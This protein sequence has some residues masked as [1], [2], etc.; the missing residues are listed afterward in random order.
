VVI[1]MAKALSRE[2]G[3]SA[4]ELLVV[5]TIVGILGA[6]AM[7]SLRRLMDTQKVRSI[8]SDLFADLSYARGEAIAR[9]H[10][11]QVQSVG[12]GNDWIQGWTIT[13]TTA[14]P[15]AQLKVQG[16]CTGPS[17]PTPCTLANNVSVTGDAASITFDRNGRAGAAVVS[18][19]IA[20]TD[21]S[22]TT[23]QKRCLKLD[24]S[25]RPRSTTGA[26]T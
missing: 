16:P 3:F 1:A 20:P 2:A 5:I 15:V 10:T 14:A 4:V 17:P 7:P 26:C 19:N 24:P 6:M 23:D 22:A 9:G 25:G 12:G 21:A 8:S 11:I 18:F 13:D